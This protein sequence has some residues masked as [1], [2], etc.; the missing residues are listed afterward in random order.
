MEKRSPALSPIEAKRGSLWMVFQYLLLPQLLMLLIGD[1]GFQTFCYHLICFFAVLLIFRRPL[2]S[3]LPWDLNHWKGI[4]RVCLLSL[5][6]YYLTGFLI[7]LLV[8]ALAPTFSNRNDEALMQ[9]AGSSLFL[10]GVTTILL[11]PVSEELLFRGLLFGQLVKRNRCLGYLV[12]SLCFCLIHLVGYLGA[13]TPMQFFLAFLQYL[14][15]GLILAWSCE[16]SRSIAAPI[17]IHMVIN[18]IS[19]ISILQLCVFIG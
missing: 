9:M 8:N 1:T 18:G 6:V 13:Y 5:F 11:A 15:P 16:K 7:R 3:C 4:I 2:R 17:L 10:F 12:S 19:L 14:L